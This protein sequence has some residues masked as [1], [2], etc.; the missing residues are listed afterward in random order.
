MQQGKNLP[1]K[2]KLFPISSEEFVNRKE[3]YI[4]L[5]IA[6]FTLIFGIY[7]RFRGI[8]WGIGDF[9]EFDMDR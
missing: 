5:A 1:L 2:I 3:L 6:A 9:F 7:L 8:G 4:F